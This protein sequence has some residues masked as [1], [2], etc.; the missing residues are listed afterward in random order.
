ML[1]KVIW[2]DHEIEIEKKEEKNSYKREVVGNYTALCYCLA[3][4]YVC[5][6]RIDHFWQILNNLSI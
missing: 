3:S 4:C 1:L 6:V 5:V 2:K